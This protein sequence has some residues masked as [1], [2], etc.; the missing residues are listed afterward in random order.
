VS[1]ISHQG[2]DRLPSRAAREPRIVP[3]SADGV[4]EW[5]WTVGQL[6][7]AAAYLTPVI[8]GLA[9]TVRPGTRVL[10][11]GCGNGRLASRFRDA[12]ATVVG[13]DASLEGILAAQTAYPECRWEV[14][15][16]QPYLLDALHEEPFDL[17]LSVEVVEHLYSPS[18]WA[19]GCFNALRPGGRLVCTTPYHGYLKNLLIALMGKWD[20]HLDALHE[21]GHIKFFSRESLQKLL[22]EAGFRD[23]QFRGCGRA[24]YLWKSMAF[25]ATRRPEHAQARRPRG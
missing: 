5:G 1:T 16:V 6:P 21:G 11:I 18:D 17:V 20:R 24:P 4:P 14:E 3:P 2:S 19:R 9:G 10:D 23:F 25:C 8:M 22:A 7:Q 12:G 13:I 15:G